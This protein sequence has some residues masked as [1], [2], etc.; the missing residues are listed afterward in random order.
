GYVENHFIP[1]REAGDGGRVVGV[2]NIIHD[3]AQRST[4]EKDL[5]ALDRAL[6]LRNRELKRKTAE[7]ANFN[8]IASHDLKEPL[9]KIYTF[10]EM[11][12]TKEGQNLSDTGRSNLRRAQSAVQ[13]MG[14]LTDDIV[15]FSQ[16][17]AA[18]E[19][20]R[21]VDLNH[22]FLFAQHKHQRTI[23]DTSAVVTAEPLPVIAGYP[24]LLQHLWYHMLG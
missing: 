6:Q 23:E 8:W 13:R 5:Q 2:L 4:A 14:L 9:R 24:D 11:V 21:E 10:I 1:L 22:V 15:T 7:L 3:V 16:V 20:L 19:Q 17:T 18:S 12:A